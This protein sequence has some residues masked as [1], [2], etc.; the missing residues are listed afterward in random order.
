MRYEMLSRR[1]LDERDTADALSV[2]PQMGARHL[3]AK[4]DH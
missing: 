1:L 3:I 2:E 4:N